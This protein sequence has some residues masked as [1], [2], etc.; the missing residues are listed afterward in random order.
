MSRLQITVT[1]GS[2]I[3]AAMAQ[4]VLANWVQ[5]NLLEPQYDR[6]FPK[7]IGNVEIGPTVVS[8]PSG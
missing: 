4:T 3:D 6:L 7:P 2:E 8:L 1:V 5:G